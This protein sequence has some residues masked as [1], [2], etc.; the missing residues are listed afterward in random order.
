MFFF[1]QVAHPCHHCNF[2]QLWWQNG[3]NTTTATQVDTVRVAVRDTIRDVRVDTVKVV[4]RDTVY[5]RT[6]NVAESIRYA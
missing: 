4:V 5:I 2:N 6:E 3:E 1:S